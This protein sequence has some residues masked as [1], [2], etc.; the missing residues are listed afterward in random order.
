MQGP[1][2]IAN[3]E[4]LP[5]ENAVVAL[6]DINFV[7]G[8]GVYENIKVRDGLAYFVPMHEQRLFHSARIIGL[9]HG[10]QAGQVVSAVAR[11]IDANRIES[12]NLKLLLVG[13]PHPH[14]RAQ[15]Y[16]IALRSAVS[17]A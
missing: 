3:E 11:L 1:Y 8:Y 17:K 2:F 5:I 10:L 14:E 12:A 6:D 16:I 4:L 9:D 15:L 13:S 7:Y